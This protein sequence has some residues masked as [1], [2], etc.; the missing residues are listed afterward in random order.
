MLFK[1]RKIMCVVAHVLKV[2]PDLHVCVLKHQSSQM[3]SSAH[4]A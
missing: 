1:G 3:R 2:R 4:C